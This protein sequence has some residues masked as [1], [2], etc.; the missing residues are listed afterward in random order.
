MVS[1]WGIAVD[2]GIE[3]ISYSLLVSGMLMVVNDGLRMTK[4]EPIKIPIR[5]KRRRCSLRM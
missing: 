3:V 1:W 4:A 5:V 2:L